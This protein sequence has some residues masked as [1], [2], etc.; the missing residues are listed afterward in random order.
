MVICKN[1]L[2]T[3]TFVLTFLLSMLI[4]APLL[5]SKNLM[6]PPQKGMCYVTWDKDRLASRYSDQSLEKLV[7]MGVEY[8][9]IIVTQY[10]ESYDS[11]EI[12]RMKNTPSDR[13]IIHAIEKAHEL[14]LKVMLKPHVDLISKSDGTYWRADIGCANEKK[15]KKWFREYQNFLLHYARIAKRLEVE[16]LCVGTELSFTTTKNS[17]WQEIISET[18]KVYPGKLIYA[19][20]W[21]NYKNIEFW[22][23]LDYIGIDAYFPLTS[24]PE[25]SVADL[26]NGWKKW[27]HEIETWQIK[28]NKPIIFTEIGYPS[29]SHAAYTPWKNTGGNGIPTYMPGGRTTAN[30]RHKI[31]PRKRSWKRIIRGIGARLLMQW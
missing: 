18:R 23:D 16:I 20:N 31:N 24:K 19:A 1:R 28:V 6:L 11:T 14:G 3:I 15:K 25:P 13:S 9:S 5:Y 30:S 27:I 17:L 22:Q 8:V 21:D 12:K 29:T 7:N 4:P 26:I 10:Q 2:F